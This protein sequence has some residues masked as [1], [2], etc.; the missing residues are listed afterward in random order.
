MGST[1]T[2][3]ESLVKRSPEIADTVAGAI[4]R[5]VVPW[6]EWLAGEHE[7]HWL[8]RAQMIRRV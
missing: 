8:M 3:L 1:A 2:L 4:G 5:Q 6:S 7:R